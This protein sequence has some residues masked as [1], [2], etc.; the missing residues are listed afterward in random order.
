ML[1]PNVAAYSQHAGTMPTLTSGRPTTIPSRSPLLSVADQLDIRL[2]AMR[3]VQLKKFQEMER[4]HTSEWYHLSSNKEK[5][6]R[7]SRA[8]ISVEGL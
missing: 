4:L 6:E 5:D 8:S 2:V 1:Y 3:K 7:G